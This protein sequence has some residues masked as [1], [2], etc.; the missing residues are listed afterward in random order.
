MVITIGMVKKSLEKSSLSRLESIKRDNR[1][2]SAEKA[3][4]SIRPGDR[5]FIGTGC[6]EPQ[7]LTHSL[8]T[9]SE[10]LVDTEILHFLNMGEKFAPK[11]GEPDF[12]RHNAFFIGSS[13]RELVHSGRCDYT[14]IILSE[15]PSLFKRGLV[16]NDVALIQVSPP[17]EHGYCSYGVSVDIVKPIAENSD[18]IIA[19]INPQMPRT[20]GDS[21]IHIDDIDMFIVNDTSIL[22]YDYGE[23]TEVHKNVAK[24]VAKLIED[25]SCIQ[26]GI[27]SIPNAVTEALVD[28]KNL[29]VHTEVFSDGIVDLV[30][31]GV[32]TC[33]RKN[34]FPGKIIVSFVMGTRKL[35][36]FV[37]NNPLVEFHPVDYCNDIFLISRNRKQ[38]AINAAISVDLT[39][40]VNADSI[41][42]QF[43]SGIGGQLDFMRGAARSIGGKPITVLPS[44]TE[45]GK[46]SRIV[47]A[48]SEGSEVV[49]TRGDVHYVA[50]EFGIVNLYGKTIRER[51]L[52]MISVAHPDFREELLKAAKKQNYV[53]PDQELS[54]TPDGKVILY[55]EKYETYFKLK[56]NVK[57]FFRPIWTTDERKLQDLFYS[58]DDESRYFR[59]FHPVKY[60]RHKTA[61]PLVNIDHSSNVAIVVIEPESHRKGAD[62]IIAVGRYFLEHRTNMAEISFAVHNDWRNLGITKLLFKYLARI[63]Q[64]NGIK[65]FTGDII[66][67]NT[68]M[69]HIVKNSGYKLN[70]LIDG[71]SMHF[72]LIFGKLWEKRT[73][74]HGKKEFS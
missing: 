2:I 20:L 24:H 37:D 50:T 17:D 52:A 31:A 67:N 8:L 23:P 57:A 62:E 36:N 56:N 72:E 54:L 9:H 22:E 43:Y 44:T 34:Q 1:C 6:G 30:D 65:G 61:Q 29:G 28:K 21:F 68:P 48:L 64:E 69:V 4:D 41:G 42:Y 66:L 16:H 11:E 26:M 32:V 47:P 39:G 13:V 38:V 15:I 71:S 60:F 51:V 27:G 45:D 5:I 12:F 3:I 7:A 46:V 53:Y 63:A 40:Q 74:N 55:P 35:Y 25:E 59:F 33:A 18:T 14:P 19:E 58:L 73:A 10:Q 70:T 49:I